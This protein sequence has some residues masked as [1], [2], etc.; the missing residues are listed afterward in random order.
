[1]EKAPGFDT[2]QRRNRLRPISTGKQVSPTPR[3]LLWFQKLHE[4]G[5]LPSSYLHAFSAITHRSEKRAKERLTDLFNED[6]TPHGGAYLSRPLQQFRTI[7]S[8]YNQLVHDLTPASLSALKEAG[9]Y[10][11]HATRPSGPWLH[12]FMTACITASIEIATLQRGDIN[13]IPGWRILKRAGAQLRFP[14][15]VGKTSTG[16]DITRDLIPDTI[17]GLEYL[18]SK[19][20]RYRF[21]LVEADRGTEPL[22][23]S[24]WNRKSWQRSLTQYRYYVGQGHYR[25]HLN[26]TAPL[27][28]L[29]VGTDGRKLDQMVGL[30][31]NQGVAEPWLLFT[32]VDGFGPVFRPQG[33]IADLLD[34]HWQRGVPGEFDISRA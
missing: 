22:T 25:Q 4:H 27:L 24:N 16:E 26:L 30:T 34:R 23:T 20:P 29:I 18:T 11:D 33:P 15:P 8:R 13:F 19:G 17:F 3:D 1:M 6:Q 5:P 10:S 31:R 14:A 12:T 9:H 7:D 21:F 32:S 2:I 28:V